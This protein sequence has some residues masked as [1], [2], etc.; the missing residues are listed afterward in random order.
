M[1]IKKGKV[2][3][4]LALFVSGHCWAQQSPTPVVRIIPGVSLGYTLGKG[5]NAGIDCSVSFFDYTLSK[6]TRGYSGLN[7][8][9]AIFKQEN[10]IYEDGV[11]RAI[12]VNIMNTVNDVFIVKLGLA[13][14]KLKWGLNNVNKSYS[15]GWGLN[16][17][18]AYAFK[19]IPVVGVRSFLTHNRCMGTSQPTFLYLGYQKPVILTGTKIN[20]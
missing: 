8:S 12:S 4:L 16:L 20:K 13:K 6:N 5:L 9:Y 11:Y 17:D 1:R 7:V 3:S 10:N 15:K 14:T 18:I 2:C 19:H